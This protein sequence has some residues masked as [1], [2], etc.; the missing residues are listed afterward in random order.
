MSEEKTRR[1]TVRAAAW[2][3][4][5]GV[6]AVS[7]AAAVH[8]CGRFLGMPGPITLGK[9]TDNSHCLVC[10]LDFKKESISADHE[11][12]GIGCESCHGDSLAH[13]DDE[14]NITTPDLTYGR[15]EIGPLRLNVMDQY[16]PVYRAREHSDINR[17]P[18]TAEFL[19]AYRHAEAI[20]HL[21]LD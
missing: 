12:E 11:A 15:E 18:T 8:G 21:G 9:K 14:F 4:A 13:G 10:H 19:K 2:L 6:V 16:R 3:L 17:R 1:F 20:G 7:A 5:A